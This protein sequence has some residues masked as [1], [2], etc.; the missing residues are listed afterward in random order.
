M[1]SELPVTD[2]EPVVVEADE[3]HADEAPERGVDE[4]AGAREEQH[5]RDRRGGDDQPAHGR[6]LAAFLGELAHQPG[7]TLGLAQAREHRR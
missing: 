1:P 2:L 6:D 4:D 3:A 5:G 7:R